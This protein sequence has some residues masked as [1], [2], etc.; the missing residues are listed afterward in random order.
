MKRR[1]GA[2]SG[3][4][5]GLDRRREPATAFVA[6]EVRVGVMEGVE[7]EATGHCRAEDALVALVDDFDRDFVRAGVPEKGYLESVLL[8]VR[9]LAAEWR[10]TWGDPFGWLACDSLLDHASQGGAARDGGAPTFT[11]ALCAARNPRVRPVAL[12]VRQSRR[13]R[14]GRQVPRVA[15]CATR[16]RACGRPGRD[17]SRPS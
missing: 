10:A 15:L 16:C 7:S 6:E 4:H 14:R 2:R 17:A 11:P 9:E 12:A 1:V 5:R 3:G 8:A 13:L